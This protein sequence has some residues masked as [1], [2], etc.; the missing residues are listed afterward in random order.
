DWLIELLAKPA[1]TPMERRAALA[2]RSPAGREDLGPIICSC[3]GVRRASIQSAIAG[4]AR[5]VEAV[6]EALKAGTNCGSCRPEIKR[7]IGQMAK[8]A[9]AA[10]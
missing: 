4:G 2:G 1:L 8:T 3:F 7:L 9:M 6:G 10:E 5:D